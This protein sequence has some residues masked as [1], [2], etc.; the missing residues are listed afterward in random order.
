ML[1]SMH[2]F[3]HVRAFNF[4][5]R[6]RLHSSQRIPLELSARHGGF[7]Q[8]GQQM[9]LRWYSIK[10]RQG[11]SYSLSNTRRHANGVATK[12]T[13]VI[14]RSHPVPKYGCS[15]PVR[16]VS[17]LHRRKR[18][19]NSL[20]DTT[21]GKFPYLEELR[22]RIDSGRIGLI[23]ALFTQLI[24]LSKKYGGIRK[25][26]ERTGRARRRHKGLSEK[27][28]QRYL[29]L[30]RDVDVSSFILVLIDADTDAYIFK[31]EYYS[32]IEGGR[33]ASVQLQ[34]SIRNYLK[35]ESPELANLPIVIKAFCGFDGLSRH[36]LKH[37]IIESPNALLDF[38]KGFSQ[39]S[40][41]SDFVLLGPGKD[42]ADERI[43]GVFRQ[44]VEN[45]TCQ[46]IFFG[47]C[48][49][50]SYVRLLEKYTYDDKVPQERV[51]L[52]HSYDVG[53]EFAS[54]SFESMT[55]NDIF[56]K[57]HLARTKLLA[58]PSPPPV[59]VEVEVERV[60]DSPSWAVM[61]FQT[62]QNWPSV[63]SLKEKGPPRGVVSMSLRGS[64]KDPGN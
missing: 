22:N 47:A 32:G 31:P 7:L 12:A 16:T 58:S 43:E 34:N 3:S 35:A 49:D 9:S 41:L 42:R 2:L 57:A 63:I 33:K 19:D 51:V 39:A 30:K 5:S 24:E 52:L 25:R 38:V 6:H 48:H 21:E 62:A 23:K 20:S 61:E 26:L 55:V 53:K 60:D 4:A 11:P 40:Q 64:R 28:Q 54:L 10:N 18:E 13:G 8:S 45:P 36:L 15:L 46:R 37:E 1:L 29:D 14:L 59:E 56:S 44:F 27:W 50:N 17:N